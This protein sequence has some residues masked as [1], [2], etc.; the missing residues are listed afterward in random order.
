MFYMAEGFEHNTGKK[1]AIE[2]INFFHIFK[3]M[4]N[5]SVHISNWKYTIS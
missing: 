4:D 1:I 5:N 3:D 2:S